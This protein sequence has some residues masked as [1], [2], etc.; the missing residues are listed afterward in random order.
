[1]AVI[2][3]NHEILTEHMGTISKL[4]MTVFSHRVQIKD[5]GEAH[6]EDSSQESSQLKNPLQSCRHQNNKMQARLDDQEN[7]SEWL[8]YR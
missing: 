6:D 4:Q 8:A 3:M 1:M 2:S 7:G 5:H